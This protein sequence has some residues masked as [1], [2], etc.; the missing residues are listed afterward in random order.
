MTLVWNPSRP[1]V[2][3]VPRGTSRCPFPFQSETK[4]SPWR[5]K[6]GLAWRQSLWLLQ[7]SDRTG[8]IGPRGRPSGNAW[9][10]LWFSW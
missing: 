7:C 8:V 5:R 2:L 4:R 10:W 9:G 6:S 1:V 3:D